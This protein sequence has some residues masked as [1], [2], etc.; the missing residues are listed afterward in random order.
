MQ[1]YSK[2]VMA[3]EGI[4]SL[5]ISSTGGNKVRTKDSLYI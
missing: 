2:S 3:L 1:N 5:E 4:S